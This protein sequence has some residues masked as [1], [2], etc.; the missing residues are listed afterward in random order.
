MQHQYLHQRP[1]WPTLTWDDRA[2]AVQLGRVRH[3]QGNLLGRMQA[4]GFDLRQ[5]ATLECLTSDVVNTS[6]I[7]GEILDP[8]RVRSSI[9]WHLGIATQASPPETTT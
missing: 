6:A 5:Q 1:D 3:L 8:A 4:L 9:A 2:L 7:E